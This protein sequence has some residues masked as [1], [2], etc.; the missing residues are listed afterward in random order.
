ML[1]VIAQTLDQNALANAP[2]NITGLKT[3]DAIIALIQKDPKITR[4]QM[5]EILGK[6]IRTIGRAIVKLQ[7]AGHLKRVGSDKTGHW[8]I[9]TEV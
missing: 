9:V 7:Q 5:A 8:K 4:Q 3:P 6:D 2:V 1:S